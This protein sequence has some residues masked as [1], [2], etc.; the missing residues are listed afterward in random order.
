MVVHHLRD[1]DLGDEA[2]IDPAIRKCRDRIV[3]GDEDE[4]VTARRAHTY[5][6]ALGFTMLALVPAL[7]LPSSPA[8]DEAV[9]S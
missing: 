5:W 3:V 6:W 9:E 1:R 8:G 2:A 4:P 7:L